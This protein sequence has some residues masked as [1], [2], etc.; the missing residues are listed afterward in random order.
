MVK[1]LPEAKSI[2]VALTIKNA[3]SKAKDAEPKSKAADPRSK[4]AD[5]KDDPP[6]A[7]A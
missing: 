2:E 3:I 5:P 6:R 4:A 7:K 1:P